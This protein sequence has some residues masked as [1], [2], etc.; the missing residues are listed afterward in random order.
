MLSHRDARVFASLSPAEQHAFV[1][2][3]TDAEAAQL[4]YLWEAWA[5][6]SQL[7]PGGRWSTWLYMGGRGAGKTRAGSEWVRKKKDH[8]PYIHLIGRTA[9]DVRDV[10]I[11]GESGILA[12]SPLWDKP[13]YQ[14]SRRRLVWDNGA[15]A[16]TFSADEPESLRGPQCG[17]LWADEIGAWQYRDSWDQAMFGLRLGDNPQACATTTPRVTELVRTLIKQSTTKLTRST[18]YDNKANLAGSF[19]TQVISRYEQTR[20]GRQELLGE[21]I[22]DNERALWRR[23]S[24]I[25]ALRV[26]TK[27]EVLKRIAVA[28]DPPAADPKESENAAEAG[29]V[30]A[31]LGMDHHGYALADRSQQ[32]SPELWARIAITAYLEYEADVI[33]VEVNQG[34]AMVSSVLRG[35]AKDMGIAIRIVEVRA[36]RG[37][38]LRAEPVSALYERGLVHHVGV[39][40]EMEDQMCQWEPGQKSPDRLDAL[41][42]ALTELMVGEHHVGGLA[43]DTG[44]DDDYYEEEETLWR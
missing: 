44:D 6:D 12:C 37:K 24:M 4:K 34:G 2:T 7:E 13:T 33:V 11:C 8:T 27:P 1:S 30:V 18:T 39:F 36:T 22:E 14:P 9:A 5:R 29:I 43:M 3:L 16:I 15:Q 23:E 31:G 20:L 42:W 21:L 38:L 35:V 17:A 19:F 40:P 32:A 10:M 28:I 25:E 41:V 26:H